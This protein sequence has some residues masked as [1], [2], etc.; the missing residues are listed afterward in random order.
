[1]DITQLDND[2]LSALLAA[3]P[4]IQL[5]D[6]RTP[7]E[8]RILGHISYS[9]GPKARNIPMHE[10]PTRW[11]EL[12]KTQKTVLVCEHGVRSMDCAWYLKQHLGFTHV[13]NLTQG[14]AD[15]TGP[16]EFEN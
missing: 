12:D 5:V 10:L 6:V 2:A 7:E 11:T 4:D 13:L 8:Y 16:R 14:M 1:M 3:E 15:W 9:P